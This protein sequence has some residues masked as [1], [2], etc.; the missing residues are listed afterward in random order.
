MEAAFMLAGGLVQAA[1]ASAGQKWEAEKAKRAA[2]IGRVQANQVDASYRRELNSTISSIR[3]FRA[4][5]GAAIDSP[6]GMAI[7]ANEAAKSD[8]DRKIE[9]GNRRMQSTQDEADARFRKSA[10]KLA[11]FGGTATSLGKFFGS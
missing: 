3:A 10:A 9:V 11:L 1:G 5:S 4:S 6:T 8:R 7:E 2:E